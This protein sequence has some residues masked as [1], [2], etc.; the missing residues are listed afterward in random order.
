MWESF[1]SEAPSMPSSPGRCEKF[2][3]AGW[4]LKNVASGEESD[5]EY[6]SGGFGGLNYP[7]KFHKPVICSVNGTACGGGFERMLGYI[8]LLPRNMPPLPFR[9]SMS[10]SCL[11]VV[12]LRR[13]FPHHVAVELM[14]TGR[15][16]DASECCYWGLVSA[17]FQREKVCKARNMFRQL[18]SSPRSIQ[19]SSRF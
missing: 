3:C 9:K 7:R 18:A 15:W 5:S 10:V 6:G 1:K 8:L 16:M 12:K 11:T 19:Q 14:M 4:D 13:R 2:F 17:L